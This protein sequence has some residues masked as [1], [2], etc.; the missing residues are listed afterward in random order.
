[1]AGTQV[2]HLIDS[3]GMYGAERVILTL[4]EE[5][6]GT[7]FRGI[8]GCIR[9]S[10][11]EVPVI[12]EEAVK[13]GLDV[14]FF[15]MKRGLNVWGAMQI[16]RYARSNDI[17]ILHTH[18]Y[19]PN[20][21]LSTVP[22]GGIRVV[23][24]VHGWAKR[25]AGLKARIY[26]ILDALCLRRMDR[27]V[28]VSGAVRDDLV[29]RGICQDAVAVIYNGLPLESYDCHATDPGVRSEFGLAQDAFVIG[30]VGRLASVKGF[31][32]LIDAMAL[33]RGD[34]PNC[35][36]IVA[37]DGPLREDLT[38][39]IAV[40]GLTPHVQLVGYQ[41]PI[42][43]FFSAIDLFVMPSLSEGLPMAL[44]EA[45]ACRKPV[46]A[47]SVGG[48]PEVI[49]DGK[50]GVL[51]MP[52]DSAQVADKIRFAY[53]NPRIMATLKVQARSLVESEFSSATMAERYVSE[54]SELRGM[55]GPGTGLIR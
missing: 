23:S 32:Y 1:M 5:L 40:N 37:G 55:L 29:K 52:A 3:A 17:R 8:L 53:C 27:I 45:M 43:R 14:E 4:L 12:A 39:R 16:L 7:S 54:Y 2:L 18:G 38:R 41:D 24:T 21:L 46:I 20:I 36:L 30:A 25:T 47:S 31:E 19:K 51:M 35:R 33:V 15:T 42:A 49:T 9:E 6:Q 10:S 34:I 11:S 50:S 26:E 22:R 28:A 48:I 13:R 44:L